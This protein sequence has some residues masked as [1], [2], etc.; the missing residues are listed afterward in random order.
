MSS[1]QLA[2]QPPKPST[3][4]TSDQLARY[5]R[6]L[7]LPQFG[8]AGQ[9]RLL[10][11]HVLIVGAG[12]LGSP[13]LSY[14]AAAGVGTITVIDDDAVSASNLQRQ[15]IHGT[16][17]IGRSKVTSAQETIAD[18]NP[19]VTVHAVH[20]RLTSE[21]VRQLVER[22]DLV[23]D[24]TDNFETRYLLNDT[25]VALQR[26]YIWAAIFQFDAQCSV[27][28][29]NNGPCYRCLFPQAPAPGAVPSCATGGVVGILPGMVGTMQAME[30]VKIL[31]GL[32]TPLSGR[33]A[34]LDALDTG[35]Q[36]LPLV[37]DPQ[38]VG[39]G[40]PIADDIAQSQPQRAS[41]RVEYHRDADQQGTLPAVPAQ[42]TACHNAN[43]IPE[44]R[45]P[46]TLPRHLVDN[47][48][49]NTLLLDVRSPEEFTTGALE[50]ALNVPLDALLAQPESIPAAPETLV[51]CASG[52]RSQLAVDTLT[53]AG[54][55]NVRNLPG[56]LTGLLV[57]ATQ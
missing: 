36:Y 44:L 11:S 45:E 2:P 9:L 33:I 40:T 31:A 39:C 41:Q 52:I 48:D 38:C 3:S 55:T 14:L 22:V 29:F 7:I 15:I 5:A 47:L 4:L 32:G 24:G 19:D 25:C 20:E 18:L 50:G 37:R 17:D 56:G 28:N 23:I 30:A 1:A 46:T 13:V 57:G 16:S 8:M 27:F 51:Y 49:H 43:A 10:A 26:P 54:R 21:N 12:G 6:Q 35:W 34:V 53:A 42:P